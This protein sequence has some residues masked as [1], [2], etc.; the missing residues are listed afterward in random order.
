MIVT[1]VSLLGSPCSFTARNGPADRIMDFMFS[2]PLPAREKLCQTLS[3]NSGVDSPHCFHFLPHCE[4]YIWNMYDSIHA[5]RSAMTNK[6]SCHCLHD[7]ACRKN[8]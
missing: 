8:R 3:A 5:Q 2:C 1:D 4:Q 6:S 7:H